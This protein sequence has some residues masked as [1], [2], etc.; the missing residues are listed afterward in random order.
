MIEAKCPSCRAPIYRVAPIR[1]AVDM[2][3]TQWKGR[4]PAALG[5]ICAQCGVL[6]PLSP[7]AERDDV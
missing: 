2:D 4:S 6:L 7:A 3:D 1:I 5:F